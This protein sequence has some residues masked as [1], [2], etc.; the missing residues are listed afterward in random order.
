MTKRQYDD[1]DD[2]ILKDG[3]SL[4]VPVF[5]LDSLGQSVA[6]HYAR[7]AQVVDAIGRVAGHRPGFLL[8][9]TSSDMRDAAAIDTRDIAYAELEKRSAVAWRTNVVV[10]QTNAAS[11]SSV[12]GAVSRRRPRFCFRRA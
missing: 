7:P 9:D 11:D 1:D 2:S 6:R 8:M 12:E 3:E 4:H 5:L 10:A